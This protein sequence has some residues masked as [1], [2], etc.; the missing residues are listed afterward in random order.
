MYFVFL[1][2]PEYTTKDGIKKGNVVFIH[3]SEI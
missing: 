3:I 1:T 2:D